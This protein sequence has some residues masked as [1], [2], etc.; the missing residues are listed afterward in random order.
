[1]P[2]KSNSKQV[3]TLT[4]AATSSL[5]SGALHPSISSVFLSPFHLLYPFH[6][7]S[8]ITISSTHALSR[9]CVNS[10]RPLSITVLKILSIDW[11]HFPSLELPIYTYSRASFIFPPLNASRLQ[12]GTSFYHHSRRL[13]TL[14][15]KKEVRFFKSSGKQWGFCLSAMNPRLTIESRGPD[16]ETIPLSRCLM[17]VLGVCLC[18][19]VLC[20]LV[21]VQFVVSEKRKVFFFR[22]I[23]MCVCV[24]QDVL[25][26]YSKLYF[27]SFR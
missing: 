11:E 1:M 13:H 20:G 6:I 19:C 5:L 27:I 23:C 3:R 14:G 10:K 4:K 8:L 9:S 15:V 24:C 12:R 16:N 17:T 2:F 21:V 7:F 22:I 25:I 18:V 26:K